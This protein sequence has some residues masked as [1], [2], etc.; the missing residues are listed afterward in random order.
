MFDWNIALGNFM[1]EELEVQ[2]LYFGR[3]V[4]Y[5]ARKCIFKDK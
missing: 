4:S 5:I 3:Y 2:T 1:E